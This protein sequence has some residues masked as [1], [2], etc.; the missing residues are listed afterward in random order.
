[1]N[2]AFRGQKI[3]RII[4]ADEHPLFREGMTLL[5]ER[6]IPEAMIEQAGRQALC[7]SRDDNRRLTKARRQSI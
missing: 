5:L 3:C 6:L 2:D 4:V 7:V 1:M